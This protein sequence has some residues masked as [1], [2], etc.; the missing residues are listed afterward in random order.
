MYILNLYVSI[1]TYIF[2]ENVDKIIAKIN[3]FT[4]FYA[5]IVWKRYMWKLLT[6]KN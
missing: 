4:S 3:N 1:K 2:F 5:V 6:E